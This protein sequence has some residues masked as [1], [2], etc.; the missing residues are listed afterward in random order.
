MV[1]CLVPWEG[2]LESFD[3]H[4]LVWIPHDQIVIHFGCPVYSL[5]TSREVGPAIA[6]WDYDPENLNEL[7]W[8]DKKDQAIFFYH[9]Q[10]M[11]LQ[12][13]DGMSV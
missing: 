2:S 6:V 4:D 9:I 13:S 5:L 12:K 3:G 1:F 7:S 10:L 11:V 8:I